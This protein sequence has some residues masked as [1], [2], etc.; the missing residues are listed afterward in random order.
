MNGNEIIFFLRIKKKYILLFN[1][2]YIQNFNFFAKKYFESEL[3]F[4]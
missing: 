3:L 2:F 1:K 4:F